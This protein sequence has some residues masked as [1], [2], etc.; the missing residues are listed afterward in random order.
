MGARGSPPPQRFGRASRSRVFYAGFSSKPLAA[1]A[2]SVAAI[3]PG[4]IGKDHV[5]PANLTNL[6][7]LSNFRHLRLVRSQ[8]VPRISSIVARPD[9]VSSTQ[10]AR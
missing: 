4:I 3:F 10:V 2:R 8:R 1:A 5:N 7:R 6:V 9:G